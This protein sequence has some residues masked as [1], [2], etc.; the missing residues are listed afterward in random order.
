MTIDELLTFFRTVQNVNFGFTL[1]SKI[2]LFI[3]QTIIINQKLDD[4]KNKIICEYIERPEQVQRL[5]E[6]FE[7]DHALK[8]KGQLSL[9]GKL[10]LPEIY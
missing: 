3:Q 7:M 4:H 1:K 2:H 5:I 10:K 9:D 8:D 6:E